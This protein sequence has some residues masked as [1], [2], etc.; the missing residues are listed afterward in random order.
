LGKGLKLTGGS[1]SGRSIKV[2][3]KG[4]RPATNL[5]R[6]AIFSTLFSFFEKGVSCLNVLDLFSGT[7]SL[8]FE[9]LS[10]GASGVTFVDSARESIRSIQKNLE[11]LGFKGEVVRSDVI[12]FL[13]INKTL[14]YDLV[15][16]DPPYRYKRCPEVVELLKNALVTNLSALVVYERSY[17]KELPDFGADIRILR[18][19]KYGQTELLYYRI[20]K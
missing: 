9:A 4:V 19:K 5:V 13:K 20:E 7:G 12:R 17:K 1:F 6:E 16:I 3:T 2:P 14:C 11:D 15:F 8:G 10:R 18:R